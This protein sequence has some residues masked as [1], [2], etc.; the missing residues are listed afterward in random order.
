[1]GKAK[2]YVRRSNIPNPERYSRWR[3]LQV[4]PSSE[5]LGH[6]MP[7]VNGDNLASIRALHQAA[8]AHS[9]LNRLLH[10]DMNMTLG[11][12]D[13]PKVVRTADQNGVN[14][15]FPY[16]H[17]SLAEFSGRLPVR[18][19][20]N[21]F[22]KRYLFKRATRGFLPREI[23]EKKK[24]G[25][26]LPIGIW[27]KTDPKLRAMSRDVLLSPVAYQRGYFRK[28]FIEK[29]MAHLEQDNTPYYG[30]LLWVFLMLELWHRKHVAGA[31]L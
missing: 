18:L 29:L 5:V 28:E 22:E 25:F 19:K 12:E 3:L 13:L 8:P 11:D 21:G 17:H 26:G 23:L 2:A 9:E 1:V 7:H 6:A 10:I 30:D 4:F 24:H 27:L 20:V 16:L 14:V 31:T 15:R